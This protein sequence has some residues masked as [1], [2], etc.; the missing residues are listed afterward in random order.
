MTKAAPANAADSPR[1]VIP[2]PVAAPPVEIDR[3]T[4]NRLP[5]SNNFPARSGAYRVVIHLQIGFCCLLL[6]LIA[7]QAG[8]LDLADSSKT[9]ASLRSMNDLSETSA[10]SVEVFDDLPE[11]L[12]TGPVVPTKSDSGSSHTAPQSDLATEQSMLASATAASVVDDEV[13]AAEPVVVDGLHTGIE[14][15]ETAVVKRTRQV[16]AYLG[17]QW[18]L[19]GKNI[20]PEGDPLVSFPASEHRSIEQLPESIGGTCRDATCEEADNRLGT[21]IHWSAEPKD[22]YQLAEQQ[23]KLVFLIHVSGNFKIPGFT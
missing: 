5:S 22:A 17:E 9:V 15:L 13:L 4:E 6:G 8:L 16:A 20:K 10:V 7:G 19:A 12:I 18:L 21:T 2:P 1:F 3:Q 23:E 14:G 11:P